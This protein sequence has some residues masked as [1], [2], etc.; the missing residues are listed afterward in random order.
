MLRIFICLFLVLDVLV[1][2]SCI[3]VGAKAD[4]KMEELMKKEKNQKI[5]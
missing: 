1:V 4:E 2:Y 5:S 3:R